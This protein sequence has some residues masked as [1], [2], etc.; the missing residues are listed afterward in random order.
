MIRSDPEIAK[1]IAEQAALN[2]G[3]AYYVGGY[4]RDGIMGKENNDIDIHGL[5]HI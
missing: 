5:S 3:R 2:G 1:I 4:V